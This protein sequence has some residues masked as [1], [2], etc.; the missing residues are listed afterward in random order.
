MADMDEEEHYTWHRY[1]GYKDIPNFLF[2]VYSKGDRGVT[3]ATMS[4]SYPLIPKKGEL[5]NGIN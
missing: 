5:I 1:Y 3:L 2:V 4:L